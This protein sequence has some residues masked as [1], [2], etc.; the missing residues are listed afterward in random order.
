MMREEITAA[1]RVSCFGIPFNGVRVEEE[2]DAHPVTVERVGVDAIVFINGPHVPR[3]FEELIRGIAVERPHAIGVRRFAAAENNHR[4]GRA[5]LVI[6][7]FAVIDRTPPQR[8]RNRRRV[9]HRRGSLR[10]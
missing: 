10:Q 5:Q 8:E 1:A 9:A 2:Q 3:A 7:F 4:P 6:L